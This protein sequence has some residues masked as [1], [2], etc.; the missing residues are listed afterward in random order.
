MRRGRKPHRS[1]GE[2]EQPSST[3][4]R[5]RTLSISLYTPG[6]KLRQDRMIQNM[7]WANMGLSEEK[8]RAMAQT[9]YIEI[10]KAKA[11]GEW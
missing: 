8:Q 3:P 10:Q 2:S 9:F 1:K 5:S 11:R 6:Q 4:P 7:G